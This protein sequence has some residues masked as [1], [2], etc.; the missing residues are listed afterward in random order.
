[1]AVSSY[2]VDVRFRYYLRLMG[3]IC[4]CLL[5]DKTLT[6]QRNACHSPRTYEV[7]GLLV[8]PKAIKVKFV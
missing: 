1:M 8:H 2:L 6:F 7:L 3:N 5:A 4:C